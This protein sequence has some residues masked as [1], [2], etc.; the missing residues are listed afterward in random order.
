MFI[1]VGLDIGGNGGEVIGVIGRDGSTGRIHI[2]AEIGLGPQL[3]A[4]HL[5]GIAVILIVHAGILYHGAVL[6]AAGIQAQGG[7]HVQAVGIVQHHI[8]EGGIAVHHVVAFAFD[9]EAV[10]HVAFVRIHPVQQI[11]GSFKLFAAFVRQALGNGG[12]GAGS[13]VQ[14]V[15]L[16]ELGVL[17]LHRG[18]RHGGDHIAF[19]GDQARFQQIGEDVGG[20]AT[21][22]VVSG[23]GVAG[24]HDAAAVAGLGMGQVIGIDQ[25]V[26]IPGSH[27]LQ[28]FKVAVLHQAVLDHAVFHVVI[29]VVVI[30]GGEDLIHPFG[31]GDEGDHVGVGGLHGVQH[32]VPLVNGFGNFQ[33]QLLQD[34]AA[35]IEAGGE[36]A[37]VVLKGGAAQEGEHIVVAVSGLD[38]LVDGH[39]VV[40]DGLQVGGLAGS[41]HIVQ[42]NDHFVVNG[43]GSAAGISGPGVFYDVGHF[44]RHSGQQVEFGAVL[45]GGGMDEFD[46]DAGGFLHGFIPTGLSHVGHLGRIQIFMQLDPIGQLHA[47]V[48]LVF[49]GKGGHGED[50]RQHRQ[51]QAQRYQFLHGFFSFFDDILSAVPPPIIR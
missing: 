21:A 20:A 43:R 2:L 17:A 36:Q 6:M 32:G 33:A 24:S 37:V 51:R 8:G 16:G 50:R 18:H 48:G 29:P 15:H 41:D 35:H 3:H 26:G 23:K 5:G 28:I 10:D 42:G 22:G 34:V 49:R 11:H 44:I 7:G 30:A 38:R 27:L 1:L 12:G 19:I 45:T 47:R 25:A 40:Q 4:G 14:A 39:F 13:V 31:T 46:F 9:A